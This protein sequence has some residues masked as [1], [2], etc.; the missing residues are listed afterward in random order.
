MRFVNRNDAGRKLADCVVKYISSHGLQRNDFVI[1]GLPRGGVPVADEVARR[2]NCPLEILV[3]KKLPLPGQPECAI[4][5]VSSDGIVVLNPQLPDTPDWRQYIDQHCQRLRKLTQDT[6]TEFYSLAGR[7]RTWTCK[8]KV[9]IIVDDGI[10]TGMT[11]IAAAQ[12]ARHR[13][14]KSVVLAAPVIGSEAYELLEPHVDGIVAVLVPQD[15]GAVG[16]Y[17]VDFAQTSTDEVIDAL[18]AYSN[19]CKTTKR[20]ELYAPVIDQ[21]ETKPKN[22]VSSP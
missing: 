22:H 20:T 1:V 10:A 14:A 17:Y 21:V 15:F 18:R 5:A 7:Q 16:I 19:T 9:V 2:L 4:G 13:G 3:S 6:E 8:D 12:T 11:A